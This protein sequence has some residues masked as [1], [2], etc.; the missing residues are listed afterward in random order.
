MARKKNLWKAVS[1]ALPV[2]GS[3]VSG[4]ANEK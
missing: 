4:L 2:C 3:A 1:T